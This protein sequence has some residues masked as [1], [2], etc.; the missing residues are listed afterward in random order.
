MSPKFDVAARPKIRIG[1]M[2]DVHIEFESDQSWSTIEQRARQGETSAA[3][4]WSQRQ[5]L[6]ATPDHPRV[7]PDLRG[8]A[9]AKIDLLLLPGDIGVGTE[10]L[11]YADAAAT[12]LRVPI[13]YAVGNHEY[14]RREIIELNRE[15]ETSMACN[16]GRVT[17]LE[18]R[19]AHLTVSGRQITILGTSLWT[20]Y[21][22]THDVDAAMAAARWHLNDHRLIQIGTRRF[23]PE[24]AL[25]LHTQAREWLAA[26][27]PAARAN[28]DFVI[29]MTHHAPIIEANPPQYIGGELSPAFVSEMRAEILDWQPDLWVWGHTHHS[30]TTE[31]GRTRLV[32]AQRGYVGSEA[33]AES[34]VPAII[35][36]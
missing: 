23:H 17:F 13:L 27:I 8:L 29:V 9:A 35:E 4:L 6:L 25:E 14:Y 28:A 12:F 1:L 20:D 32:S 11:E 22:A 18:R 24:D 26:E 7:G 30:M 36:L 5:E 19:C 21:A 34:F 15:I 16:S 3:E 10:G 2:S 31:I 33:G